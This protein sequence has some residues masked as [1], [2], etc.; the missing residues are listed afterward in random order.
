MKTGEQITN[1]EEIEP[2]PGDGSEP[3]VYAVRW[4]QGKAQVTRQDILKAGGVLLAGAAMAGCT[5]S[6]TPEQPPI[7]T[8]TPTPTPTLAPQMPVMDWN[9][10]SAK[11]HSSKILG[12]E[13]GKDG[14]LLAS[15]G[16]AESYVKLWS[17]PDSRNCQVLNASDVPLKVF[18]INKAGDLLF[19]LDEFDQVAVWSLPDGQLLNS[20]QETGDL[21]SINSLSVLPESNKVII[22]GDMGKFSIREGLDGTLLHELTHAG[23]NWLVF[24]PSPDGS[25]MASMSWESM[26]ILWSVEDGTIIKEFGF[27]GRFIPPVFS[28]DSKYVALAIGSEILIHSLPDG[29]L[30]NTL[31]GHQCEVT[32]LVYNKS[33]EQ[34]ISGDC[35]GVIKTWSFPDGVE[36]QSMQ[37][38]EISYFALNEASQLLAGMN[39]TTGEVSLWS[40]PNGSL[41]GKTS[42]GG[43]Y[44]TPEFS[45]DGTAL[46][47]IRRDYSSDT[48]TIQIYSVNPFLLLTEVVFSGRVLLR[49]SPDSRLVV[50][51]DGNGNISLYELKSGEAISCMVDLSVSGGEVQGIEY[52]MEVEGQTVTYTLPCGSAIPPGAVCVCNCVTGSGCACVGHSTCACVGHSTCS[53]VGHSTCSCV[54]DFCSCVSHSSG[55]SVVYHYWYPD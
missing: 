16:T 19:S 18:V 46:T 21:G 17:F 48:D 31:V 23:V 11:A 13:F 9:C 39:N 3:E 8:V 45:P 10:E 40:L 44:A 51:G 20:Y 5:P 49:I 33:S 50:V 28:E 42:N 41:I 26:I 24:F 7:I 29:N 25:V 55:C 12:M 52:E 34:I 4:E 14:Q 47:V 35:N 30:E 15:V 43:G 1:P 32:A 36:Q 38:E 53:C 37:A 6:P 54:A 2:N 22:H 27:P